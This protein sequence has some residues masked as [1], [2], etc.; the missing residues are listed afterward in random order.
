MYFSSQHIQHLRRLAASR[1]SEA[2]TG[3]GPHTQSC[4]PGMKSKRTTTKSSNDMATP[5]L[6]S[7]VTPKHRAWCPM[8]NVSLIV[9]QL[10]G[11]G[12]F[13]HN[14]SAF[15]EATQMPLE[16]SPPAH[17]H[18]ACNIGAETSNLIG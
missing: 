4:W 13:K 1:E 3:R 2:R 14:A 11:L 8:T 10:A 5:Q 16:Y 18:S 9:A 12:S 6:L 15:A 7:G 17:A